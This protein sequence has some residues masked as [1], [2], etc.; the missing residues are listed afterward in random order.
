MTEFPSCLAFKG[1]L[2]ETHFSDIL[3]PMSSALKRLVYASDYAQRQLP[4]LKSL[5]QEDDCQQ[6]LSFNEYQQAL[7]Q[8]DLNVS[9]GVFAKN[10]RYFRHRHLLRLLLREYAGVAKTSETLVN[11]SLCADAIILHT[12]CFCERQLS[13]RFGR[14]CNELGMYSSLYVFAM[15]K[16]GGLELNFSSDIDLIFAFSAN[17]FTDGGERISNQ[18]YYTKVVQLFIQVLQNVTPEGFVFRVDLR[19]RPNGDSG[20]L[21]LSFTAMETYYQ[22]QG[23]DWERYAMAKARLIGADDVGHQWFERWIVPFVYRRY[24][25]FSVIESMRSMKSMIDREIKQN[26]MLDDIKRGQGGIREIE[27]IIQSLQLIRGGR[28]KD[29]QHQNAMRAL[30]AL[31]EAGLLTRA[32]VLQ[33]AYLFLRQLENALQTLNDQQTHA[34]PEGEISRAQIMVALEVGSWS[35]L[36][37]KLMRYQRIVSQAFRRVLSDSPDYKDDKRLLNHQFMSLWQGH[38]E[39]NMSVHLLTD[40]GYKNPDRCYDMLLS[41]K[42]SSRCRRLTQTAKMRLD[43]FMV[44]LLNALTLVFDT[45]KVLL[46]VL[47]L[48]ENIVGRSAYLALLTENPTILNEILHWFLHSPYITSLIVAHPF[49]LEVFIDQDKSWRP[50]SKSEL[51]KQLQTKLMNVTD[52]EQQD[53]VLRQFK[54]S[55]GLL[56]ARAELYRQFDAPRLSRFLT[57]VAEVII[58]ALLNVILEQSKELTS[59]KSKFAILAYGTLGSREMNYDSDVDLVFIH[60]LPSSKEPQVVRLTQKILHRLTTR[61]QSGI[62]YFVDT[63]L[64]PSGSSGLLISHVDAFIDYQ[65]QSAWTWEHQALL[66]AR[67]IFANHSIRASFFKM[68]E[69]ILVRL[70]DSRLL[71]EDILSMREKISKHTSQDAAKYL[72]GGSL[73]VEFLVQFLVLSC[74]SASFLR[75]TNTLAQIEQLVLSKTLT[76][77]EAT[78]L[79]GAYRR[80][81]AASHQYILEELILN[82][83]VERSEVLCISRKILDHL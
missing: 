6:S 57:D 71:L 80:F 21:V 76:K 63:R 77:I 32:L 51:T 11:W 42:N 36:Q 3:H 41:F 31:K 81:Q 44:L 34:L 24:I 79:K 5:L 8:I 33:K 29:I 10:L 35:H 22:E 82:T 1:L 55:C 65:R 48:L 4:V 38:V 50:L 52:L 74:A 7:L 28:L 47:R 83:D 18:E 64:R 25:D 70:R 12:I 73:D 69:D 16:L 59:I 2:F 9:A 15:G 49:L 20:P 54:L 46:Q 66:R 39:Y 61:T 62:L 56:A 78:Q 72:P 14:A 13:L 75:C 19:L 37:I 26:P 27:F 53:E 17:G 58:L 43:R 68:K 60:A 40:L 30:F 23:R 45:D 67:V